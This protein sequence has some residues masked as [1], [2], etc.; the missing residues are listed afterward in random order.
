MPTSSPEPQIP[1]TGRVSRSDS[2]ISD[3]YVTRTPMATGVDR[4]SYRGSMTEHDN[5][6]TLGSRTPSISSIGMIVRPKTRSISSH[7]SLTSKHKIKGDRAI[8]TSSSPIIGEGAGVFTDMTD[9][10]LKVLDRRTAAIAQAH[11]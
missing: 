7:G 8:P 11:D 3:R 10:M 2:G 5:Y 9:T 6:A 1:T 4:S